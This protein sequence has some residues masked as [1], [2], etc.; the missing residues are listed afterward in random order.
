MSVLPPIVFFL[1]LVTSLLCMILLVR[2]WMQTRTQLLLW[3]S[4]CFVALAVNNFFVFFDLVVLPDTN[5]FPARQ[6]ASLVAVAV[7]LYGFIWETD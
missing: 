4:L 6:F 2:G 5:L 3:S 1:C 7:L